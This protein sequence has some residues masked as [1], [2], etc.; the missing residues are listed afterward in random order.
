MMTFKEKG[1]LKSIG[2]FKTLGLF[3]Y[4]E[5]LAPISKWLAKR[6]SK[7]FCVCPSKA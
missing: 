5:N 3:R 6:Y 7:T 4:S 2:P 1:T